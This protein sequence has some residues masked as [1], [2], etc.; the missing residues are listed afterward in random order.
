LPELA[1]NSKATLYEG[2]TWTKA[3]CIFGWV[4]CIKILT[5]FQRF[6]SYKDNIKKDA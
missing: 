2:P 5:D 6:V 1:V 4:A 3:P